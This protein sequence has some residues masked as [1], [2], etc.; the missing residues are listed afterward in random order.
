MQLL[1]APCGLFLAKV[2]PDWGFTVRG[3]RISLS[4]GLW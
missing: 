4:P 1:L 3:S 2:L